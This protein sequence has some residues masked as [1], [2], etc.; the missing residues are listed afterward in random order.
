MPL[1]EGAGST[2]GKEQ[3]RQMAEQQNAKRQQAREEDQ[4]EMRAEQLKEPAEPRESQNQ[5]DQTA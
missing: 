4:K 3:V 2:E 5:V 1:I